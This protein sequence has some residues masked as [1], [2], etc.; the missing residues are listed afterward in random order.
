MKTVIVGGGK[1]CRDILR[2]LDGD[3]LRE[4]DLDVTGVVD[5]DPEAPGVVYARESGRQ[6]FVDY[7][8]AIRLP[9]LEVILELTGEA[10]LLADI[11]HQ[12]PTGVRIIDHATARI[13]WDVITME[14]S[15]RDELKMRTQLELNQ[16]ADRRRTQH[17]LDSLPDLVVVLDPQKRVKQANARFYEMCG[18]AMSAVVGSGCYEAFCQ[19]ESEPYQTGGQVCPFAAAVRRGETVATIVERFNPKHSFWEITASPQHDENGELIQVVETHHPVTKRILLQR[20]VEQSERRFRQF[21]DSAHDIISIKDRHGRYLEYNPA[22]AALFSK[23]RIEFIGR[24][25]EEI[26][27]PEIA[28][29]ITEHDREVMEHREYRT[30]TEHYTIGGK[31]YYLQ[32]VRFPLFDLEGNVDGVCTIARDI[33]QEKELQQQLLQS[34]KLAA[35]GQLAAGVAHEIN[36]PLTG[37][38]A[39]AEDLLEE[40]EADDERRED[41]QVIIRE[42]L[43][44]RNIVRNLLDFARQDE[45]AFQ[46]VDLN[47]IVNRTLAL[48]E[49][50]ARFHDIVIERNLATEPLAVTADARQLQQVFLNL[51][52]NANDAMAGCGTIVISSGRQDAGRHCYLAVRDS[53]PGIAT[54]AR[55]RIF[56]PFFSTKSTSG[57]GLSISLGIV[58]KHGGTI[59]VINDDEAPDVSGSRPGAEFQIVLPAVA[60][61][62]ES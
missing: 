23:D 60:A 59:R 45:P 48:V 16:E 28:R 15:L 1:G 30:F 54:D 12:L 7:R 20:E 62:D 11:Y 46:T 3:H 40:S 52:I 41:Y 9:D 24:T 8:D 14:R 31:E 29:T 47:E 53:G 55:E 35:V 58:E 17:L 26:Y 19:N 61:G 51:I 33:T 44:C 2:L 18:A 42:T 39:Y 57:L 50:Q 32:T 27:E 22:S 38:L 36:N 34:A 43:R 5:T 4:L 6:T 56:E 49:K 13:F 10:E 21:V 25:A 37:V